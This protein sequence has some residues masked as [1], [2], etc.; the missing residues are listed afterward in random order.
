MAEMWNTSEVGKSTQGYTFQDLVNPTQKTQRKVTTDGVVSEGDTSGFGTKES[1]GKDD[2]LNLLMTQLKNQDPLE[3]QDNSQFIAQLAQFSSLETNQTVGTSMEGLSDSMQTFMSLQT[4]ASAS[5]TNAAS[6]SLIGKNIRVSDTD[7]SHTVG[8]AEE[9]KIQMDKAGSSGILAVKNASGEVVAYEPVEAQDDATDL[10]FS[11]DG[12]DENGNM[13]PSGTYTL[14]VL[15]T[16]KLKSVGTIY[17]E[18]NVSGIRY[19]SDGA[20]LMVGENQYLMKN[21]LRVNEN[22]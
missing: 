21:L 3:P 13:A 6:T 7:I 4:V 9:I 18:G 12:K 11:W 14:E 1:L 17:A 5:A 8:N 20:N 15:D 2:F 22:T 16:S 19:N 10:T